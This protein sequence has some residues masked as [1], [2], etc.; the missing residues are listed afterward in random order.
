[1]NTKRIFISSIT[2][3]LLTNPVLAQTLQGGVEK[4]VNPT[5][6]AGAEKFT[7]QLGLVDSNQFK[8][9][10]VNNQL[11]GQVSQVRVPLNAE[12]N[13]EGQPLNGQVDTLRPQYQL[14]A[15]HGQEGVGVLGGTFTGVGSTQFNEIYPESDLNQFGVQPGDVIISRDGY[16]D[17]NHIRPAAQQNV[18]KPGQLTNLVINHRGSIININVML[19]DVRIV[20]HYETARTGNYYSQCASRTRYW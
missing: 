16:S 11:K 6:Q 20:Q 19:I 3:I 18:Y 14:R 9:N 12:K 13:D 2:C 17:Y 4:T 10:A 7:G 5:L 8:L 1:M 15:S